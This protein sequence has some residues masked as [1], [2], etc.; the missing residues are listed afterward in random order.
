MSGQSTTGKVLGAST[1]AAAGALPFTG[2]HPIAV[3]I[4]LTAVTC[5]GIVLASKAV[6]YIATRYTA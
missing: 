1:T 4:L 2:S 6:K 5:V 3:Y